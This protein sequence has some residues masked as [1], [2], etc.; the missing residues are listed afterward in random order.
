M[1]SV[2]SESQNIFATEELVRSVFASLSNRDSF[3]IFKLAASGIDASTAILRERN[4]S[5]KRYYGRLAELVR[6]GLVKKDFG[7]YVLTNLGRFVYDA[8]MLLE[9]SFT[10][11]S[12]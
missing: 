4:F 10:N 3:E 8:T 6:L 2:Q 7:R 11:L 12:Q 1:E 9:R 5:R